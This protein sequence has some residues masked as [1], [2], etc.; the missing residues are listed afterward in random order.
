[1][2]VILDRLMLSSLSEANDPFFLRSHEI[3]AIL[4]YGDGG[5]FG[6]DVKLYHR[7]CM[8]DG[9]LDDDMLNDGIDF[10]R[11]SLRAGRR[12]LAVGTTGATIVAAYLAEMGFSPA[13]ARQML[14]QDDLATPHPD[15]G[16][17]DAHAN[18]LTKRSNRTVGHSQD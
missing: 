4:Y 5:M 3:Q 11:E 13:Q 12:V 14:G 1:M 16:L 18:Q 2:R 8:P 17:L 10:L 9:S 6:D 7:P 15:S